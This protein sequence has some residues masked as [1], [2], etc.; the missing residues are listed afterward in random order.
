MIQSQCGILD[1]KRLALTFFCSLL[2]TTLY[3]Q[4]RKVQGKISDGN[5]P[6]KDVNIVV[7]GKSTV[8]STDAEGRYQ[9]E[10]VTG[11]ELRYTYTGM[12]AITIRVE[13]ITKVL[14][15]VMIPEV[16]ELQEVVV[17]GSK[18]SSQKTLASEYLSNKN[19]IKT[20]WGYLDGEKAAGYVR[21]MD[22]EEVNPVSVCILDLLRNRFSGLLVQGSCLAAVNYG[23]TASLYG[24]VF[25]RSN[26]VGT[27]ARPAIF[28][29]DGQIFTD[30]PL[31]LDVQNIKRI[32][33]LGNLA[34]AAPY[35]NIGAGGVIVINTISGTAKSLQTKDLA[36]LRN[37]YANGKVLRPE[38][39]LANGPTYLKDLKASGS[40]AEAKTVFE[41]YAP[42]FTNSP[43][44]YLDAY[45]YFVADWN[46]LD[47]ADAV[48]E[49]NFAK[50]EDNPVLL[51]ALAYSYEAQGRMAKANEM[52]KEVFIRRSN[53]AQSYMD[54]ANSYRD[55][56]QP[57]LA[58]AMYARYEYLIGE[59]FLEA[60]SIGFGP[61]M[62]REFNNLL[63]LNRSTVVEGRKANKLYIAKEDFK[64]TRLVFEW[65]DGEA[66]FELQFVNPENQYYKWKHS[67]AD[68]P[69]EIEREKDF[70]YNVKEY[71]IDS[72][73]PG[74]WRINVNYLGNK[75]LSPTYLKATVYYNYGTRSQRKETQVFKL[76]L[77]NVNEQLFSVQASG[78]V[79]PQ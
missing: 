40:F 15:L 59:G 68:T 56:K 60:D 53:Y 46:E 69:E 33:I 13:D 19:I 20:A 26:G 79:V 44:F 17:E 65:N 30:V 55:L 27:S 22:Q 4:Q 51:K 49:N 21:I 75:S 36:R 35:G 10:V 72:A 5:S 71:L 62:A 52:Y 66:E 43:Y 18:R 34:T 12:R 45:R 42:T 67:L 76:S 70:G 58:A 61:V 7:A 24:L 38:E 31:W 74:T 50:F 16:E 2:L 48:I 54:M 32:G 63:M 25:I 47:Y 6:L 11:D 29:V 73:L 8:A 37:N 3:A 57:R 41:R 77:K 28:D 39:I 14:N 78:K 1:K 23:D 64:G 9:I